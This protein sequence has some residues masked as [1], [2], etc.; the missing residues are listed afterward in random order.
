MRIPRIYQHQPLVSGRSVELDERAFKH[1]VHVLRFTEG[2]DLVLFNG[3]GGEYHARLT[4]ISKRGAKADILSFHE[5]NRES[6]LDIHLAQCISKGDRFDFAIQKAVELGVSS[7]T[8]VISARSQV[9]MNDERRDKKS[10]HWQ[11]IAISASEQSGRTL[12]PLINEPTGLADCLATWQANK[13]ID[14]R[15]ILHPESG[16]GLSTLN[17]GN[18][19][20]ILIGPEGGFEDK[21]LALAHKMDFQSVQLGE[22]ILRTETAPLVAIAALHTLKN[23]Y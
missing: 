15:L 16:S 18:S 17:L 9:K 8:P 1:L 5:L 7:I 20:V 13:Q 3:S 6:P 4:S 14:N 22:L 23:C 10:H 2:R 19:F 21:E 11:Q 12:V